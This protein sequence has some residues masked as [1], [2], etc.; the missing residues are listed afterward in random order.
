[1]PKDKSPRILAN[2]LSEVRW[3]LLVVAAVSLF[4]NLLAL[5]SPLYTSQIFDH[6]L[7]NGRVETLV[8]LTMIVAFALLCLGALE[9]IRS[10][11]LAR[12]STWLDRALAGVVLEASV[13]ETLAGRPIGSQA[14]S[15]LAQLRGFISSQGIFPI[16]DAPWTPV[17]VVVIWLLHPWLGML[18]LVSAIPMFGLAL[19]NELLTRAPLAGVG[20]AWL[21]GQQRYETALRNA[22]VVQAMGML[23]A[24]LERWQGDHD[25]V[26][27]CQARASYHT[28]WIFGIS[29]FVRLFVQVAILGLG[30]YLTL[31][32][33]LTSGGMIA[34]S[35]L[36][37]RALAPVE[38]AIGAWKSFVA[39]RGSHDRLRRLLQLHP[40]EPAAIQL[41]VP[42]G[43]ISVDQL[44]FR[45][46]GGR[47]ILKSVSFELAAGEVLAVVGPSASGKST[48]CRLL[49]GVW[50]P[51]R[52]HVRLDGAEVH[53]WSRVDFGRHVGYL[54]QD[55]ELF[56]GSV[57][58]N[59]ARM[60]DAPDDAVV[61]AAQLAG[62][63]E[64]ILHLPEGY[65]TEVGPQGA[66]LS[67]GQRQRIG[68][69]RAM[70]G[71]PRVVVLDEP[72]ASLDQ[73]GESAVLDAIGRLKERGAT[74]VLVVHRSG[75]LTH[76][77][78]VLV[79]SEGAG[80]LF[81]PRD[82]IL[83]RIMVRGA[84][85]ERPAVATAS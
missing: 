83:A 57:R 64:M 82:Q 22:E 78:K 37:G 4:L 28:G 43:R 68:L 5:T 66:V 18:A 36:L 1:M 59:I 9:A 47:P 79:L 23:P 65:A 71:A 77:D 80:V 14:M 21:A 26:L 41:P 67:G 74:V 48:L 27:D 72:S 54:P 62:V 25:R 33:D 61:A 16:F 32:G 2:A 75:L 69:A 6:V 17:F 31:K 53:H 46:P 10:L 15:D 39:A 45:S 85:R 58:D 12:I 24:L 29:K 60:T 8:A 19:A 51:E 7:A 52:G 70:F 13:G 44:G 42:Q 38:Q 76:V 56:S 35:I 81:G 30:A 73:V 11:A 84:Q 49:T 55:V 40:T 34:S 20:Q 63:H 3:G 50:P